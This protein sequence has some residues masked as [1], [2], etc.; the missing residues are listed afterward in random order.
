MPD[1]IMYLCVYKMTEAETI[2]ALEGAGFRVCM[3]PADYD[4]HN[5]FHWVC[6][7]IHVGD[8]SNAVDYFAHI[9]REHQGFMQ[10]TGIGPKRVQFDVRRA[11]VAHYA[12]DIE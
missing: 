2:C 7:T 8:L 10:A 9:R 6:K 3:P 1:Y 5:A 4:H 12:D 11:V